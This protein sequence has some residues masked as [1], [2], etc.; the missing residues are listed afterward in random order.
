MKFIE[1][2]ARG[3]AHVRADRGWREATWSDGIKRAMLPLD[4]I[5]PSTGAREYGAIMRDDRALYALSADEHAQL[6]ACPLSYVAWRDDARIPPPGVLDAIRERDA[7]ERAALETE[8]RAARE[9]ERADTFLHMR[10]R[11]LKC[12][13]EHTVLFGECMTLA[14]A[15]RATGACAFYARGERDDDG[16]YSDDANDATV[17]AW[18]IAER[19]MARVDA[20]RGPLD[21]YSVATRVIANARVFTF[22]SPHDASEKT[23]DVA[24]R[25]RMVDDVVRAGAEIEHALR[26]IT[27]AGGGCA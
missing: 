23:P 1:V 26:M 21:T 8:A 18:L 2:L 5:D 6:M 4:G 17:R 15:Y 13:A 9:R 19:I 12:A 22:R 25:C 27:R 24:M 16:V 7:R 3:D 10:S 14:D 11:V 20:G